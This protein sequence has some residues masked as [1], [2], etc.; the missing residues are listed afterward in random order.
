MGTSSG[1][2]SEGELSDDMA[3]ADE[4]GKEEG[5]QGAVLLFLKGSL[6]CLDSLLLIIEPVLFTTFDIYGR[7][8]GKIGELGRVR[9]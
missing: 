4:E 1:G 2:G 9:P 5:G 6:E 3:Q 8:W 7:F